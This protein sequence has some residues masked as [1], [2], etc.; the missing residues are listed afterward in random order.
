MAE[1]IIISNYDVLADPPSRRLDGDKLLGDDQLKRHQNHV[2]NNRLQVFLTL[3]QQAYNKAHQR[4]DDAE[5]NSIVAKVVN[6]VCKECVPSG[7][8]LIVSSENQR[9]EGSADP[10]WQQ[11]EE[12]TVKELIHSILKPSN[13]LDSTGTKLNP[14]SSS[15]TSVSSSTTTTTASTL[16]D[17]S[18]AP[19][20]QKRRRR[21]SLLR[22]SASE[23]M[24]GIVS[25]GKKKVSRSPDS[26]SRGLSEEPTW[27]SH[28]GT[29][30]DGAILSLNRMDVILTTSRDALDPN[31]ESV[32]N[33]RLHILVAM[34][35]GKYHHATVDGR[36]AILNEVVLTV[37]T[38]WKGR[39][40]TESSEGYDL[41]SKEDAR[42]ALRSIFE[43]RS[44]QSL[45]SK[46]RNNVLSSIVPDPSHVQ[47]VPSD[48]ITIAS[49]VGSTLKRNLSKQ[50]SES[51]LPDTTSKISVEQEESLTTQVSASI[52]LTGPRDPNFFVNNTSLG[53]LRQVSASTVSSQLEPLPSDVDDLRWAAVQSL[54]KQKAR[55]DIATRLENTSRRGYHLA[56]LNPVAEKIDPTDDDDDD[57]H[58]PINTGA[59]ERPGNG[60]D[61]LQFSTMTEHSKKRQ[62]TV[63]HKLDPS[64]MEQLVTDFDDADCNDD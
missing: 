40:L 18:I 25:D 13:Q 10:I 62:S 48:G 35:S 34:Q 21:S 29:N 51:M 59:M 27:S 17:P 7:R 56:S 54:Q 47:S 6:T 28:R 2:G 43:M 15:S 16:L 38:F 45:L 55:Q 20:D 14:P 19:D 33:N 57:V 32:G 1:R 24:V 8:F 58:D 23:G 11:M 39:F 36:E 31:S 30:R 37:N 4:G 44:G 41:L 3:Y 53:V 12:G 64:V 22:R 50:A 26:Y 60:R 9:G 49:Q 5:C 52:R 46:A 61:L 63:F 42:K